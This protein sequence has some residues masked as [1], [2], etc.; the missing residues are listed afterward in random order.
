MDAAKQVRACKAEG[1]QLEAGLCVRVLDVDTGRGC[2]SDQGVEAQCTQVPQFL[3]TCTPPT[4]GPCHLV[5]TR[6]RRS[7]ATL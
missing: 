4:L 6:A 3:Q 7:C 5:Y 1:L 2:E